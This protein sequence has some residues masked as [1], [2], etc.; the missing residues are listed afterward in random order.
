MENEYSV[1][2]NKLTKDDYFKKWD[3]EQ[4]TNLT[5]DMKDEIYQKYLVKADVFQRDN[6]LC[7]SANCL[8]PD[9]KLTMHHVKFQ[10]NAGEHKLKNC[11]TLCLSCHKSFHRGKKHLTLKDNPALP[12]HMRGHTFKLDK[13]DEINWNQI[14]MLIKWLE[15]YHNEDLDD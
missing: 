2:K 5:N 7:Q 8:T 13:D 15:I 9:S 10:K 6:F 11:V 1:Y 14:M 4:L 12:S 3:N